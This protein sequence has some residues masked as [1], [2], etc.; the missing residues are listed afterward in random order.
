MNHEDTDEV[1][2]QTE[3][4]DEDQT[5][6]EAKAEGGGML[7]GIKNAFESAKDKVVGV[8]EKVVKKD[9]DGDGTIGN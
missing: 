2:E 6:Q 9:L 8:A 4:Q 3:A 1:I 7:G 5:E